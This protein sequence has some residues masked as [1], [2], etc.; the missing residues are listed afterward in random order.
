MKIDSKNAIHTI[1]PDKLVQAD[2]QIEHMRRLIQF[3]TNLD[4]IMITLWSA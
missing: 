4:K 1:R 3:S 2:G